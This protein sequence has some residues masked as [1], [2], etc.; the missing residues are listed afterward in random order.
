MP[1]LQELEDRLRD[2][3]EE[4]RKQKPLRKS[5]DHLK[6]MFRKQKDIHKV[7][8]QEASDLTSLYLQQLEVEQQPYLK[9]VG[10]LKE[11]DLQEL[12]HEEWMSLLFHCP[13]DLTAGAQHTAQLNIYTL[14]Q[15]K[16]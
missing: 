3:R 13:F 16:V 2:K 15:D 1:L 14:T 4:A 7:L 9:V 12:S 10:L 6:D 11:L 5:A 8:E